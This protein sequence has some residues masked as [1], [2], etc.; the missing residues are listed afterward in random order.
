MHGFPA[1][2]GTLAAA[3]DYSGGD[4]GDQNM[5]K[6]IPAF[7]AAF[8]L[9]TTAAVAQDK[10]SQKFITH[11]IEGNFA[12][13]QMG[14]LAQQNAQAQ[15]LKT[16][17][18]TLVTDHGAAN[19]QAQAAAKSIGVAAPPTG[20]NA[21]QK[22]DYDKMA[23]LKGAA[24]DKEFAKHMVADHK[25]DVAEYQKE[26]KKQDAAGQYAQSTLP[27]LQKHLEMSQTLQKQLTVSR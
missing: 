5:Y 17:G 20:P 19:E 22:A 13:V 7:T 1:A 26:A 8:V 11:A 6:R 2:R 16:F 4:D 18:Q 12:E 9:L 14:Q 27:T 15:E 23:K 21:K 3:L 25:K 24:F 10:A